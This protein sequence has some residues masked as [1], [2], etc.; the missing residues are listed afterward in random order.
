[1]KLNSSKKLLAS[2]VRFNFNWNSPETLTAQSATQTRVSRGCIFG[3]SP[4][5]RSSMVL[6]MSMNEAG[7]EKNR[8]RK[9]FRESDL[10]VTLQGNF[11]TL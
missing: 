11:K 2:K 4:F 8:S 7:N 6:A 10:K 5:S 1:M 9:T 3:V